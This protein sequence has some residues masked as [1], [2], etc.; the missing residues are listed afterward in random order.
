MFELNCHLAL[1]YTLPEP[2]LA[3]LFKY[4]TFAVM[5][6]PMDALSFVESAAC[7]FALPPTIVC[8]GA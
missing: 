6:Y 7:R 3:L 5:W 2:L 4:M 1:T 8:T